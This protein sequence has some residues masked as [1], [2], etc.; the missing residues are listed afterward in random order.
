M[1]N[2][3]KIIALLVVLVVFIAAYIL[4]PKIIK[5]DDPEESVTPGASEDSVDLV[6]FTRDQMDKLIITY[7]DDAYTFT[8]KDVEVE[9]ESAKDDGTT[10]IVKKT[11][12]RWVTDDFIA[13]HTAVNDI[14]LS[15]E[16]VTTKRLIEKDAKD[17]SIYGLDGSRTLTAHTTG[18]AIATIEIGDMTPTSDGYYV[19]KGDN[20]DVYTI[21]SYTGGTLT[22]S[23]FD[24]MSKSLYGDLVIK[25]DDMT[26][27]S[28]TKDGTKVFESKQRAA[29]GEWQITFPVDRKA[30]YT[31]LS[32]HIQWLN[33]AA[34]ASFVEESPTDLAQY[35]LDKPKYVFEYNLRGV[36]HTLKLGTLKDSA[37]YAMF[38]DM[39]VVFTVDSTN[40]TFVDLAVLDLVDTFIYIPMI[41]D[42]EK[43]VINIDGRTDTM[44]ID[45]NQDDSTTEKYVFNGTE[46]ATDNQKTMFKRYYQGAIGFM[47]ERLDLNAV[48]S[49][50]AF[51]TLTYTL[52]QAGDDGKVVTVELIPTPDDYGYYMVKNKVYS[53]MIIGK[54]Q[55]DKADGGIRTAYQ[56][57]VDALK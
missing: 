17:L 3:K 28:L 56:N 33:T 53:G 10:E 44:V 38:D 20:N 57:L 8:K 14:A 16:T 32:K 23:K 1:K 30:D 29:G 31:D 21:Y 27:L 40:L 52:K 50:K 11:E 9:S 55:L 41:Y 2:M 48:P 24:L 36:N 37:Y 12:T 15:M 25:D 54:R 26:T 51:I 13:N 45:V 22:K 49:G 47:G 35:G 5:S 4:L 7:G 19:K 43:L 46:M 6:E 42:V 34:I 18:G 39:D